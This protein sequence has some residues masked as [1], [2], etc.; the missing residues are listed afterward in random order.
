MF[1]SGHDS[2][3]RPDKLRLCTQV[4]VFISTLIYIGPTE[5]RRSV[6]N[7]A[8]QL[9]FRLHFLTSCLSNPS[10]SK[11]ENLISKRRFGEKKGSEKP[12]KNSSKLMDSCT[13]KD[14]KQHLEKQVMGK[15]CFLPAIQKI[16]G[17]SPFSNEAGFFFFFRN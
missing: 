11:C 4:S 5:S 1:P 15:C 3:R 6:S 13:W 12:E 9:S 16:G 17:K 10:N 14:L 8:A 2:K 7:G